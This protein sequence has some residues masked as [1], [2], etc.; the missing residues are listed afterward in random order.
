[1]RPISVLHLITELSVGG[2]QSA[3]VRL[4]EN[5][6]RERFSLQVA[7]L[8]NGDGLPA[9]QIR[10]LG[11]PV[12]D[13][14]MQEDKR[15]LDAFWHLYRLLR[16]QKPDILHTWLFH[17]NIPGRVTGRLAGV[18]VILSSERTMEMEGRT[19][20]WLNRLTAPLADR[21]LCVSQRVADFAT[22]EIGLPGDRILVIPNG[23]D[24]SRYQDLPP[25][26]QARQQFGLPTTGLLIGAVSRARPV[27]NLDVLL[28]AF[29]LLKTS[30]K[31]GNPDLHLAIVGDGPLLPALQAQADRLKISPQVTFLGQ[32]ED[33]PAFLAS[34]DL[35]VLPS[36][37]EGMPNAVLEAMAAGKP[38]IATA[39][40]GV[41]EIITDGETGLLVPPDAPLPLAEAM[42]RLLE[43]EPLRQRLEAAG[44]QRVCQ[45]FSLSS[46]TQL[47]AQLYEELA[48][49]G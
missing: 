10:E 43:D 20:R 4:L 48:G 25:D 27:K 37:F 32:Q 29:A 12:I 15:R 26:E 9:R 33:I 42:Q 23:V 19:R 6:D 35:F 8:Y 22:Q 5:L 34:L 3:L 2:A 49:K 39:V 11:V 45:H 41:L 38:V 30:W 31:E 1:M 14:G 40:G 16:Q 46:T 13:L 24:L 36:K 47:T 18:P 44:E 21:I 17:A 28:E 7:C